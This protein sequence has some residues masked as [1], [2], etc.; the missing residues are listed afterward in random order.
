MGSFVVVT[1]CLFGIEW[2]FDLRAH[3]ASSGASLAAI[4]IDISRVNAMPFLAY[5]NTL[6]IILVRIMVWSLLL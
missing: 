4:H 2:I 3:I 1:F 5:R 6:S